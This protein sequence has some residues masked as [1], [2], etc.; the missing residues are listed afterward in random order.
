MTPIKISVV[1]PVYREEK[2]IKPFLI[3]MEKALNNITD[4][5]EIL[6]ACDPSPDNT[7]SVIT[8][9]IA[10]N[11]KIRLLLFS[12]RFGQPAATMAG[13]YYC[14]GETCLVIDVDLQDPPELIEKMFASYEQGN[15]VVYAK[16]RSREGETLFKEVISYIGYR[17]INKLSDIPIP[18]DTGD[19]RL[20]SRRVI[21]ELKMLNEGHGYLRGLVAFV[22]FKQDFIEYDR[23]ARN[24]GV[25]NYNRFTGSL[26]IGINGLVS[27]SSR[28]LFAMSIIGV[29]FSGFSF[30]LGAWYVLQ[31]IIGINLTPGLSTTV[32]TIS[33]FAGVQLMGLG[34]IGEYVGRIY[35]EVKRRPMF[36]VDKKINFHD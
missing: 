27:F 23:D 10:R 3:R 16:R 21:E 18:P 1:V 36:I 13:I 2:N 24:I 15:D 17:L 19:F 12:R 26:K 9:E 30:L 8:E 31:K 5:Y 22:G 29:I 25:G 7:V 4:D 6:F 20:I 28:P 34:L 14:K 33:F 35:D 32:L 11:N